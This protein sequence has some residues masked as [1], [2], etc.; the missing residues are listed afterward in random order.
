MRVVRAGRFPLVPRCGFKREQRPGDVDS[1]MQLEQGLVDTAELLSAEVSVV[2][3]PADARVLGE[4][5]RADGGEEV[6]ICYRTAPGLGDGR[7]R[8]EEASEGGKCELRT[9]FI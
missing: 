9:A 4:R 8:E 7:S 5:E 1:R 2:D 6:A 3:D